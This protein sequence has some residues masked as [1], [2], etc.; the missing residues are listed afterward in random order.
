MG[1]NINTNILANARSIQQ[2]S[3]LLLTRQHLGMAVFQK[4]P[5]SSGGLYYP[6]FRE[7]GLENLFSILATISGSTEPFMQPGPSS[8]KKE[9]RKVIRVTSR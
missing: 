3:R 8:G 9:L 7:A 4:K 1:F 2:L 5:P 6:I